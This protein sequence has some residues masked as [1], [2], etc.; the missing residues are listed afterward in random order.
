MV[1]DLFKGLLVWIVF[2]MPGYDDRLLFTRKV[3]VQKEERMLR[4][5]WLGIHQAQ[6]TWQCRCIV[7]GCNLSQAVIPPCCESSI[8][9][10]N[11]VQESK[12]LTG[13][14]A[15][16]YPLP[17]SAFRDLSLD[18]RRTKMF[19]PVTTFRLEN[20]VSVMIG[21]LKITPFSIQG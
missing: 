20:L 4:S 8:S 1:S 17:S 19:F 12:V 18:P 10:E 6:P 14:A 11:K 15:H 13:H 16:A 9:D 5:G 21:T 2:A 3:F 7:R